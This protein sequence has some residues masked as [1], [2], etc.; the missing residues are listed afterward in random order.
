[1]L[2][3][4][5]KYNTH[6]SKLVRNAAADVCNHEDASYPYKLFYLK[7]FLSRKSSFSEEE[8]RSRVF[9]ED[10]LN[11]LSFSLLLFLLKLSQR[12]L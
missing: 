9:R 6:K 3:I 8:S 5:L 7:H 12:L 4:P 11:F 1:M 2:E 10:S